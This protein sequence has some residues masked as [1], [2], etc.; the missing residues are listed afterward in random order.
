MICWGGMF[1]WRI[2]VERG[3]RFCLGLWKMWVMKG[4]GMGGMR[5]ECSCG[6]WRSCKGSAL[7]R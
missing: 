7:V 2:R 3:G 4:G 5:M 6:G 1:G